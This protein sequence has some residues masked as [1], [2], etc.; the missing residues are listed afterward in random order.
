MVFI[1]NLYSTPSQ[2]L[3]RYRYFL[4]QIMRAGFVC[5]LGDVIAQNFIE[6]RRLRDYN[7]RRTTTMTA[8]G[9]LFTVKLKFI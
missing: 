3:L 1:L 7:V 5:G 9:F 6:K 8:I 4:I 2:H